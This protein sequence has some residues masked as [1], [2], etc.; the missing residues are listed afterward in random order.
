[1]PDPPSVRRPPL[2]LLPAVLQPPV[3]PVIAAVLLILVRQ[4]A[5]AE[6]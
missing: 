5:P 1:M 4:G 6:V 2:A 3:R